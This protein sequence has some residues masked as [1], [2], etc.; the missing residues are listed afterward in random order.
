MRVG[1]RMQSWPLR[2][3]TIRDVE[4]LLAAHAERPNVRGIRHIV[5]WHSEPKRT[6]TARDL[7][8][9]EAWQ[10]GFALLGKYGL[11]FDLQAYPGQFAGL[12]PLI[13]RHPGTQVI[14]N[15]AGMMVG[16]TGADAW[17]RG[18]KA[19]A[20]LHNV[21]V[22]IS[23]MG[24]AFRPWSIDQA[25]AYVLETIDLF[26]PERAMFASDFPTDKL[27]GSFDQ[28]LDAYNAITAGFG[29]DERK[30]MFAGNANRL[31]RLGLAL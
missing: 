7:T 28:H 23:G 4:T 12:A 21:A 31:Y 20:A 22:K 18:M 1:F 10:A 16:P 5:N 19:L 14:I 13:A 29:A 24:F 3:S 9:D 30:A 27:F 26:G 8:K 11:S 25:R 2:R 15:H 17:R 6:Y